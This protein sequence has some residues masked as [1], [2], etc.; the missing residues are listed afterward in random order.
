MD[1]RIVFVAKTNLNTDGRILNQ[2][3]ILNQARSSWIIDFVLFPDKK[4]EIA[5]SNQIRVH[6]VKGAFRGSRLLRPLTVIE[7]TIKCLNILFRINPTIIHAQDSA[8]VLPVLIFKILKRNKVFVI[9]DDHE[10]PNEDEPISKKWI[11]KIEVSLIRKADKVIF[12]NEERLNYL[13]EQ[14]DL[15]ESKLLYF[16]NLSYLDPDEALPLNKYLKD[17]L[18]QIDQQRQ[19]GTKFIIHQGPLKRE[20]G[21]QLLA[22]F[23]KNLSHPFKI[24]L[25]GGTVDDFE[26]FT[27]E[28]HLDKTKFCFVGT[29]SYEALPLFWQRGF[30][31]VVLYLPKL[32]NNR[33]CAPNRL[34]LALEHYL[35]VLVNR[36]NP[37]LANFVREFNAGFFIEDFMAGDVEAL[38]EFSNHQLKEN[39]NRLKDDQ[40]AMFLNCYKKDKN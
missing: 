7:W 21:R 33:L 18:S 32:L 12:A 28:N 14:L 34:Y 11:D 2:L 19:N 39:L 20:R 17:L 31:S 23:S 13:K 26:N 36:D 35:P 15:D 9:Y 3:N 6:E 22:D 37:V 38:D 40:I 10:L 16:L 24:L 29:V 8:T 4:T 5:L 1:E 30:A 27:Q 25:L